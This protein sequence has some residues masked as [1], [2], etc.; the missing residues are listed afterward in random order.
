MAEETITAQNPE[1]DPGMSVMPEGP[2]LMDVPTVIPELGLAAQAL[3]SQVSFAKKTWKDG[4]GGG[5]PV[6]A[7]ELNRMEGGISD[8]AT[9]IN[10]LGDSVSRKTNIG[11]ALSR[12]EISSRLELDHPQLMTITAVSTDSREYT[13]CVQEDSIFLWDQNNQK[14]LWTINAK[15]G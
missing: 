11:K 7:A 2:G 14:K 8:C 4:S 12:A 10:K 1:I 5:T 3:A 13:L 6:T 9:Q 15:L